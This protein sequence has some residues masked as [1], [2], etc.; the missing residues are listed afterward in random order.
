V[1]ENNAVIDDVNRLKMI[2]CLFQL[3]LNMANALI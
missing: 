2:D 1:I 3:V